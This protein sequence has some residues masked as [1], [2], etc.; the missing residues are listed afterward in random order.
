M[1]IT[2]NAVEV[3]RERINSERDFVYMSLKE[4]NSCLDEIEQLR[5]SN[6]EFA[7]SLG[8][9]RALAMEEAARRFEAAGFVGCEP[10]PDGMGIETPAGNIVRA[11]APLPPTLVAVPRETLEKATTTLEVRLRNM[12]ESTECPWKWCRT[13]DGEHEPECVA[14]DLEAVCDALSALLSENK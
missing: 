3:L 5:L 10:G 9:V 12:N 7:D 13:S 6:K 8:H 11:L 4:Q 14:T 1:K 2:I